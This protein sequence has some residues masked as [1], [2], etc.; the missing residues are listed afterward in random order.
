MT[1]NLQIDDRGR[2]RHLLSIRGLSKPLLEEI[3]N[4]ALSHARIRDDGIKT[5]PLLQGKTVIN[6]FFEPSTRTR[7]TFELA[8]KRLSA[9]VINLQVDSS[10][11]SKGETLLDTLKTLEAMQVNL[12]VIRHQS[13]GAAH[14]FARH[15]AADISV[16]NAGDGCHEHPTQALLDVFTLKE[17]LRKLGADF[18]DIRVAIVGDILHSRVARSDIHALQTLGVREIRVIGPRT[19]VPPSIESLG[20]SVFHKLDEGLAGVD[21][22]MLLRLQKERMSDALLP[23]PREFHADFGLTRS[24][25]RSLGQRLLIMHPGPINRGIEIEGGLAYEDQ[26]LILEQVRNGL[27]VRMAVMGLILRP[28]LPGNLFE[29][30]YDDPISAIRNIQ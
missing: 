23:S 12:F 28:E 13:S 9:D 16:L 19:L 1:S 22:A 4:R 18:E 7:T 6:L 26:S 11:R 30:D 15:T 20:V 21:V 17:H 3:L 25:V 2:L 10:S 27:A 29:L 24:R 8:A 14:F 5:I